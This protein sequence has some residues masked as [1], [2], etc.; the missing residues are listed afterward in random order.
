MASFIRLS[1]V[2]DVSPKQAVIIAETTDVEFNPEAVEIA[3]DKI[4]EVTY[5]DIGGLQDETTFLEFDLINIIIDILI[6]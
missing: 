5:E 1:V 3:E 2:A 6:N 4:L